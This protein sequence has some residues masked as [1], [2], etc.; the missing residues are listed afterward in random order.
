MKK[1]YFI[2]FL[3]L[4]F[5]YSCE[6]VIQL[7]LHQM[8]EK[9]VIEANLSNVVGDAKVMLSKTTTLSANNNF[10]GVSGALVQIIDEQG[11]ITLLKDDG[12]KG[13]Y[14]H[15]TL[16]ANPGENY[17]LRV[18]INGQNFSSSCRMPDIVAL[19]TV[20]PLQMSLIGGLQ[21]FTQVQYHDPIGVKNFYRF[22]EYRDQKTPKSAIISNDKLTDGKLVTQT[23]FSN[24][25]TMK[26]KLKSGETVTLEFLGISEDI[27]KYWYSTSNGAKGNSDSAAP[28]N[29]ISNI[30]GDAIGY[31]SVH[32]SQKRSFI[33]P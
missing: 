31:F 9:Y 26:S 4:L 10:N 6:E 12:H 29:P 32:T 15:S 28:T 22:I 20:Y 16:K 1:L 18:S 27:Y 14:T 7:N 24:E 5:L 8:N 11:L 3:V 17:Q 30:K 23:I 19:D 33:V 13:Q 2:G 25:F 21:W